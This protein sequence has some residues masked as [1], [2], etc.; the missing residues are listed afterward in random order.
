MR[1]NVNDSST[2]DRIFETLKG[3]NVEIITT[4]MR[5]P[6]GDGFKGGIRGTEGAA[7]VLQLFAD[8]EEDVA[9]GGEVVVPYIEI[10][11]LEVY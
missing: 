5:M 1:I 3:Y 7:V 6:R 2:F 11:E 4:D 9:T 10:E 8:P